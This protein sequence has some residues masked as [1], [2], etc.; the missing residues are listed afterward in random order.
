MAL[1]ESDVIAAI[2]AYTELSV[3]TSVENIA[4]T[5]TDADLLYSSSGQ[6]QGNF[7]I[8]YTDATAKV[9]SDETLYSVTFSDIQ[10][11]K[12]YAYL[13][14]SYFY[15]KFKDFNAQVEKNEGSEV[16]RF[17]AIDSGLSKYND[18]LNEIVNVSLVT[19][20][21]TIP[22]AVVEMSDDLNYPEKWLSTVK[23]EEVEEAE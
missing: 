15:R 18:L 22:D 5:N 14:E 19:S 9:T 10:K 3:Q 16:R 21:G 6:I 20:T 13:I 8:F 4:G 7:T 23:L 12:A 1:T 17:A 11:K 2:Q